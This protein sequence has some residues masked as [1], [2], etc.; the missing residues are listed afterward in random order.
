MTAELPTKTAIRDWLREAEIP[1][2]KLARYVG[3][4][5][6][7]VSNWLSGKTPIPSTALLLIQL[8]MVT[9]SR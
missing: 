5:P 1:R 9:K 3:R 4:S 8:L 2:E 6:K 7:T